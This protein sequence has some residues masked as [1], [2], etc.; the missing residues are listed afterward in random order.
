MTESAR[1]KADWATLPGSRLL[2]GPVICPYTTNY[3]IFTVREWFH[4]CYPVRVWQLARHQRKPVRQRVSM[5][6]MRPAGAHRMCGDASRR[7]RRKGFR[8]HPCSAGRPGAGSR[9][10]P[11]RAGRLCGNYHRPACWEHNR[12]FRPQRLA[13]ARQADSGRFRPLALETRRPRQQRRR[14]QLSCRQSRP[15]ASERRA[16]YAPVS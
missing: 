9:A 2:Y 3:S 10:S 11:H 4:D 13:P 1:A 8:R 12:A 16:S 14:W 7:R 6:P 5:P 15:P